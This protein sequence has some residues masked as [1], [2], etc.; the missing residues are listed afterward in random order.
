MD[1]SYLRSRLENDVKIRIKK[2]PLFIKCGEGVSEYLRRRQKCSR[3]VS[4]PPI[5]FNC[6]LDKIMIETTKSIN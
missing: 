4:Y 3:G 6:Y 2:Q 5:L 1:S